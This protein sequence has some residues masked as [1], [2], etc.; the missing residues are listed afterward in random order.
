MI[1]LIDTTA[2]K[3]TSRDQ[4]GHRPVRSVGVGRDNVGGRAGADE[5]AHYAAFAVW[6]EGHGRRAFL[7]A[8]FK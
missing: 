3:G 8:S 1:L 4:I 6:S 5:G 7:A 2:L